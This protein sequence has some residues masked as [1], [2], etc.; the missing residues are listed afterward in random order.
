MLLTGS[1]VQP[2]R[3]QS[4]FCGDFSFAKSAKRFHSTSFI[5]QSAHSRSRTEGLTMNSSRSLTA[6]LNENWY[7]DPKSSNVLVV[8]LKRMEWN[9]SPKRLPRCCLA[10]LRCCSSGNV[11]MN[12]PPL[13]SAKATF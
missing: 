4:V 2:I 1:K 9:W 10:T 12:R 5:P 8:L 11:P 3:F 7:D 6:P 13:R